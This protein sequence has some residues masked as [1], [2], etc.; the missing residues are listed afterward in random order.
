[1]TLDGTYCSTR[2]YGD[3][4][5]QIIQGLRDDALRHR[6]VADGSDGFPPSVDVILGEVALGL[7]SLP[8]TPPVA[9]SASIVYGWVAG[10]FCRDVL[11]ELNFP[12]KLVGNE[13]ISDVFG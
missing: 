12:R 3:A 9:R 6:D 1:M 7:G 2:C 4:A 10:S 8:Q 11:P 5:A 13:A